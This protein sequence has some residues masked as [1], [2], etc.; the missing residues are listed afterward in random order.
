MVLTDQIFASHHTFQEVSF[1]DEGVRQC[2]VR[3]VRDRK[4]VIVISCPGQFNPI[5]LAAGGRKSMSYRRT[6]AIV[7]LVLVFAIPY[8]IIGGSSGFRSGSSTL[9]QRGVDDGMAR[10]WTSLGFYFETAD[11]KQ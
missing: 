10:L 4:P 1:A 3:D 7:L 11:G 2:D 8:A 5:D 9:S 6:C